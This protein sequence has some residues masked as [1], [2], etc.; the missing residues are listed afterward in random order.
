MKR[1]GSVH[2]SRAEGRDQGKGETYKS[3][4]N[5]T[6]NSL[7]RRTQHLMQLS[8]SIVGS[9]RNYLRTGHRFPFQHLPIPNDVFHRG[10][11]VDGIR[12]IHVV[13]AR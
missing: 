6:N 10:V 2:S 13:G 5:P 9:F 7:N 4:V 1:D 8:V 3:V 11:G 12:D